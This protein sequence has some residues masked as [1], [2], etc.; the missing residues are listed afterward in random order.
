VSFD[1]VLD[2]IPKLFVN[3]GAKALFHGIWTHAKNNIEFQSNQKFKKEKNTF[4]F[5]CGNKQGI[6][7][8]T[9]D[10]AIC[11]YCFVEL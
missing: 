9:L 7:V 4:Y 2:T 6:L 1:H 11:L 10:Y 5:S 3:K 8:S